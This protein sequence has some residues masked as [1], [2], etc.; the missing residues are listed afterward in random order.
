M[1]VDE[2][3]L[4]PTNNSIWDARLIYINAV[5][6]NITQTS[7]KLLQ[8]LMKEIETVWLDNLQQGWAVRGVALSNRKRIRDD[9]R[10]KSV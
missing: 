6:L 8:K 10:W 5:H 3:C 7:T 2:K 1:P 4:R 9:M